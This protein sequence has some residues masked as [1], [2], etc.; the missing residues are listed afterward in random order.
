MVSASS[1]VGR[2]T[3]TSERSGIGG[4]CGTERQKD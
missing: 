1:R 3:Q 2:S 4:A